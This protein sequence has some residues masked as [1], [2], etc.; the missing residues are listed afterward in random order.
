MNNVSLIGRL[1][2]DPEYKSGKDADVATFTIA[3]DRFGNDTDFIPVKGFNKTADFIDDYFRKGM[4]VGVTGRIQ[5]Q[6]YEDKDGNKRTYTCVVA[7]SVYFA[8]ANQNGKEE[9]EEKKNNRRGKKDDNDENDKD[10]NRKN[11]RSNRR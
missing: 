10:N 5:V 7:T 1:T 6:K 9:K 11:N 2:A 4:R 8:D 3:V